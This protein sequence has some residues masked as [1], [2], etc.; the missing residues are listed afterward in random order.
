MYFCNFQNEYGS[1]NEVSKNEVSKNEHLINLC[2][3]I[4][5]MNSFLLCVSEI[6][7]MNMVLK[8]FC[9]FKMNSFLLC[10]S[11]IFKMN[12]VLK[13]RSLKNKVF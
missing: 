12:M 6:F 10:V 5:K 13:M 11:L 1:E 7:K 3:V 2:P 4:F 9:D 8:N